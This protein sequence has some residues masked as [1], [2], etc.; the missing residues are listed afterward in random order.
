MNSNYPRSLSNASESPGFG[1]TMALLVACSYLLLIIATREGSLTRIVGET[2]S[3]PVRLALAAL[4]IVL[5]YPAVRHLWRAHV[6]TLRRKVSLVV[7]S[8]AVLAVAGNLIYWLTISSDDPRFM[9]KSTLFGCALFSACFGVL[10]GGLWSVAATINK[11]RSRV[12]D[13]VID[14]T[15][16]NLQVSSATPNISESKVH[17]EGLIEVKRH[18]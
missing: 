7:A 14:H 11:R 1:R 9:V 13:G 16:G 6:W 3:P 4:C 15:N 2:N 17:Q 5:L 18:L 8:G 10:L 12:E